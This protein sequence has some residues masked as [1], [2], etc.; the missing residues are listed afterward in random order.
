MTGAKTEPDVCEVRSGTE[1]PCTRPAAVRMLGIP[2]RERCARELE[3]YAAIGDLAQ[4]MVSACTREA[5]RLRNDLLVEALERVQKEL[6]GRFAE[7]GRCLREAGYEP[8]SAEGT[9]QEV[10]R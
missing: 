9:P 1:S 2:F 10:A 5:R 6:A 4:A 8:H 3:S 7:A